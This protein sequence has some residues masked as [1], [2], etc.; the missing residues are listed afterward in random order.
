MNK[1]ELLEI[2]QNGE[3]SR[4]EFKRDDVQPQTGLKPESLAKEITALANLNGGYILLGVEDDGNVTGLIRK[5]MEEWI[6]NICSN[7][8]NP[9]IIPYVDVVLWE[10]DNPV[11]DKKIGV[12][13][14]PEDSPDKPYKARQG[15]RWVTFIRIGST[16]REATREQEQ[17]LYQASGMV[18]YDIKPVSGSTLKDLDISRLINYFKDIRG[19]DCP[20]QEETKTWETLLI[21]TE[22]MVESQGRAIPTVGGILLFGKNPNHYLPQSG[23]S[24]VAYRGKEKDYESIERGMIR[25]SIVVKFTTAHMLT[26]SPGHFGTLSDE[27]IVDRGLVERIVDFVRRNTGSKSYLMEGRRID[28]PDYPEEVVRETIVNA[29]AHRDYTISGTDIELSIYSN[30]LEVISPG[31]LPNTITIER[32]KAGCRAT[33]NELIKEVL[34]DYHYV[35]ATG[36]GVPR[37]IIAGMLKHNDTMPDLIEDEYSFTVRL[38]KEK[39]ESMHHEDTEDTENNG[40]HRE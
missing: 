31:K 17:R 7:N 34:R 1:T 2:I 12:I 32:M 27:D 8:I 23:I 6:M 36:L 4:V 33:R 20:E 11:D 25:G 10:Q 13:T 39:Q 35:E 37:K 26:F 21:N 30:R 19:Q 22:I 24:A 38:W 18:R 40:G 9:L 5:D 16:S 29:I 15:S 3:N 14:I 28:K